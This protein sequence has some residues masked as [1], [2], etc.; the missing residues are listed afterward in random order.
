MDEDH[1]RR[2]TT[3]GVAALG[4][5]AMLVLSFG[6]AALALTPS[7]EAAPGQGEQAWEAPLEAGTGSVSTTPRADET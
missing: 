7:A 5:A 3:T 2:R 1:P 6:P 4:A